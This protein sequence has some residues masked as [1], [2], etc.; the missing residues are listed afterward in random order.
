MNVSKGVLTFSILV[1]AVCTSYAQDIP[2]KKHRRNIP[3]TFLFEIGVNLPQDASSNFDTQ[4][5]GSRTANVYYVYDEGL[6]IFTRKL[7]FVPGIGLGLDRYKF[8]N[9]YTLAYNG[10]GDLTMAESENDVTKSQ[11]ITNYVDVALGL[12]FTQNPEDPSRSFKLEAGIRAGVLISSFTK[13]KY[14]EDDEKIK[15]KTRRPW[16]L[17]RFRYGLYAKTGFGNFNVMAYYNLSTLFK[18]EKG[19]DE[20][21]INNFTLGISIGGF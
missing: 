1:V 15:L 10:S 16:E 8:K 19:P 7:S 18:T 3:G 11:L 14:E 12:R 17:E 5:W 6:N 2:V 13:L 21:D 4:L 9:N 20:N